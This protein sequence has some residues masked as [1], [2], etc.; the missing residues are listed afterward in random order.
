MRP[1]LPI[2]RSLD[3]TSFVDRST[4]DRRFFALLLGAFAFLA[5]TLTVV[6]VHGTLAYAVAQ[7]RR[8]LGIRLAMGASGASVIRGVLV[9]SINMLS[10]GTAI[11]VTTALISTRAIASMLFGV[12][13]TD[14]WTVAVAAV[15]VL[16][17]GLAATMVPATKAARVDPAVSLRME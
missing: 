1:D 7:R 3:M 13:A 2:R 11:G 5:L 14:P 4:A 8:E 10:I 17:A 16:G 15:T 12:T 6:G 9:R